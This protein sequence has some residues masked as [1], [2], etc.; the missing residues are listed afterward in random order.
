MATS[1]RSMDRRT[2][3]TRQLLRQA[4]IEVMQEKG[5]TATSVQEITERANVNRGTFYAHF[6][7]KYA[8]LEA[9]IREEFQHRVI[10]TFP[11]ISQRDRRTLHV[12]IQ[13]VL[14][15]FKSVYRQ[16]HPLGIIDPLIVQVVQQELA[17]LLLTWLQQMRGKDARGVVP[18][19]TIA[20][21]MRWAIVGAAIQ[22]SQEPTTMTS[23]QMA[24]DVLLVLMEGMTH[25]T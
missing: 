8:L 3:R 20:I 17:G 1:P 7:D 21:T 11:P 13:T 14:E 4:S 9:L 24:H 25:L 18:M 22:W 15:D 12:L 16:C 5:F 23:E 10:N 6:S 19:E 2:A